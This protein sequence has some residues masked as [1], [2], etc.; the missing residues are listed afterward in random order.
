MHSLMAHTSASYSSAYE[1]S[2]ELTDFRDRTHNLVPIFTNRV[3]L[4]L[5]LHTSVLSTLTESPIPVGSKYFGFP[6]SYI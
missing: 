3:M 2:F 5:D 4:S 1:D 6:I